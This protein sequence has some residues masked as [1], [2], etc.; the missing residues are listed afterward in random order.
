MNIIFPPALQ[1][2]IVGYLSSGVVWI[3]F[4]VIIGLTAL[5]SIIIL[6]H[7][8]KHGIGVLRKAGVEI[9]YLAI[10]GGLV[11]LFFFATFRL[12]TIL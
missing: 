4:A 12:V 11:A 8:Q 2:Q 1:Q 3:F 10:T 9:T 5:I 6:W 7:W